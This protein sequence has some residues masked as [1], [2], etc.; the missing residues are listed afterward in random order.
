MSDGVRLQFI[1]AA[2]VSQAIRQFN[3]SGNGMIIEKIVYTGQHYDAK[4]ENEHHC[5]T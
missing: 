3:S 1:K 5:Y 4:I 2:N